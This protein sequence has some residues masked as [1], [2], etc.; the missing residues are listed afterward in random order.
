MLMNTP[1]NIV[2]PDFCVSMRC[3]FDGDRII[4]WCTKSLRADPKVF[5]MED[6]EKIIV[7]SIPQYIFLG[8]I[9]E[10]DPSGI[11]GETNIIK[12]CL[13]ADSVHKFHN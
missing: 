5:S 12:K 1:K 11:K 3:L 8:H 4:C 7:G 2:S 9:R 13:I 10:R 6:L